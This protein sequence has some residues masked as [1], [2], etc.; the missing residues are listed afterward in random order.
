ML[1]HAI[2]VAFLVRPD[3]MNTIVG[4]SE[5]LFPYIIAVPGHFRESYISCPGIYPLESD[6]Y[7]YDLLFPMLQASN[8]Q[9]H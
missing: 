1:S 8:I 3:Q 6:T 9:A 2:D 7:G 5:D 4:C